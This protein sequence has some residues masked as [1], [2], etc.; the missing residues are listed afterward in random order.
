MRA[1]QGDLA[2]LRET[3]NDGGAQ[4]IS[5]GPIMIG[6]VHP[7]VPNHYNPVK[8]WLDFIEKNGSREQRLYGSRTPQAFDYAD[9]ESAGSLTKRQYKI[10]MTA[11][12]GYC[13]DKIEV[14][15]IF[16]IRDR[17]FYNEFE[18]RVLEKSSA[19]HT[20]V[21]SE[22][23]FALLDKNYKGY[24][25]MDD[26]YLA[27]SSVDLNVLPSVWEMVFKEL[28]RR[29]KGYLDL[30]EFSNVLPAIKTYSEVV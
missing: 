4:N 26:F 3:P 17:I 13:P 30:D 11:A 12:F 20:R 2:N 23:L 19:N 28:D 8:S 25:V 7:P 1:Y 6:L 10:A 5:M 18:R 14:G 15:R 29:K 22:M 16:R 27:S 21:N 24:L 9:A